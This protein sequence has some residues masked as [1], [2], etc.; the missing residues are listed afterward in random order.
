M[1]KTPQQKE[2]LRQARVTARTAVQKPLVAPPIA[3][4]LS[5]ILP[6]L[7][8]IASRQ[9]QRGLLILSAFVTSV[10]IFAWRIADLGRRIDG[11]GPTIQRALERRPGFVSLVLVALALV[12]I[13]S[14]WDAFLCSREKKRPTT[15]VFVFAL[16]GFFVLGW[17]I[18]E[19]D[20]VKLVREAPEALPPLSR[21]MW[22]WAAAIEYEEEAVV[23]GADVLAGEG[24]APDRAPQ[25]EG[26]PYILVEP[27][28]GQMSSQDENYR[29]VPGTR[30]T[31]TGSGFAPNAE[32][33]IWWEDPVG[34]EF[35]PREDGEYIII[36]TDDDGTFQFEM[37]MPYRL[38]PPSAEG[39]FVHT[40][41]A[42]QVSSV[43][44]PRPSEALRL[45][46]SRML[47]TIFMG[48]MATFFGIIFSIP[49]SFLAARNIMSGSRL[50]MALYY[51]TRTILNIIR[52]IEPLIWA[53]IAVVWVGL[54][55]FAGIVALTL[56]SI[57]ALGKLYSE[58]IEGIDAGP[59]EA[60]QATGANRLQTIMFGVI[61][62]M[63]SPFISFSIYRWDINVRMSTVIGLVGGGGIGFLLVQYIRLLDYRSAGIAVWFIA[64]TVATLDYVSAEIRNRLM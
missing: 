6:G 24:P 38:T 48:M 60:I 26:E 12:W 20:V 39:P 46:I 33:E 50:T 63:I 51:I 55:P 44:P 32:T 41:E 3:A 25:V 18:A 4:I 5:F 34:N 15:G 29:P 27:N 56:H 28:V 14:I 23:A 17:Q 45:T 49:V 30:I 22:P 57:A 59:I 54:G 1:A 52:S 10:A 36:R 13:V 31:I 7:G 8:Q 58:A 62:Q 11:L 47:E 9:A 61:P 21:V 37:T 43:G 40:I 53:L 16:A 2:Q 35:R 42:R 64:I 19:I